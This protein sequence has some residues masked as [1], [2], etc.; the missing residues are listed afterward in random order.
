MLVT[1]RC[2]GV[3]MNGVDTSIQVPYADMFNTE[4]PKNAYWYFDDKRQ[5]F[6][7]EAHRDIK[8]GE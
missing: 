6:V 4:T 5:G 8:K 1:S 2:F 3:K 7:V